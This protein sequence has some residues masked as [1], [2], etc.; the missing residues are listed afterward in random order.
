MPI[1]ESSSNTKRKLTPKL[2]S[3]YQPS[4]SSLSDGANEAKPYVT[5]TAKTKRITAAQT[6]RLQWIQYIAIFGEAA[7]FIDSSV[8]RGRGLPYISLGLQR[9]RS[10]CRPARMFRI[11]MRPM[12]GTSGKRSYSS[13]RGR[14]FPGFRARMVQLCQQ[15]LSVR[16][17]ERER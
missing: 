13:S 4:K 3:Q 17:Q 14:L 2:R 12:S 8:G 16:T 1:R 7:V 15:Q 11:K 5:S 6:T 10:A 9:Q